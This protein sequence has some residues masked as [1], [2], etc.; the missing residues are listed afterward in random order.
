MKCFHCKIQIDE[1]KPHKV[2]TPDGDVFHVECLKQYEKDRDKFFNET[3]HND[4]KFVD[5]L[6]VPMSYIINDKV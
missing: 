1:S 3:I 2:T 4:K 5:Y 6:G